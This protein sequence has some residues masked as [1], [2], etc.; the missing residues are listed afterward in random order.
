[1]RINFFNLITFAIRLIIGIALG[2]WASNLFIEE[3]RWSLLK[4]SLFGY[5]MML[6]YV[7]GIM[8]ILEAMG[9]TDTVKQ[10]M[11]AEWLFGGTGNVTA[12]IGLIG[13]VI[14]LMFGWIAGLF[15]MVG[16]FCEIFEE[17]PSEEKPE[18]N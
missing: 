13:I 18:D 11:A 3:L 16:S 2:H 6:G 12:T 8:D 4:S 9:F 1:M 10:G 17:K 15:H 14:V 7:F 5:G